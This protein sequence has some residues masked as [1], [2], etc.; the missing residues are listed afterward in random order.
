MKNNRL[1]PLFLLFLCKDGR[2]LCCPIPSVLLFLF[3]FFIWVVFQLLLGWVQL[4]YYP[5]R[6]HETMLFGMG[7]DQKCMLRILFFRG[8]GIIGRIKNLLIRKSL[9]EH[10][11]SGKEDIKVAFLCASECLGY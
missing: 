8:V 11:F 9:N 3:A 7:W 6:Q 10:C 2:S 4:G 5:W 1:I